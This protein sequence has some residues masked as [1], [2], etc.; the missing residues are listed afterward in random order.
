MINARGFIFSA[1]SFVGLAFAPPTLAQTAST[2]ETPESTTEIR[3]TSPL[4]DAIKA[5]VSSLPHRTKSQIKRS[6]QIRDWYQARDYQPLWLVDGKVDSR[7]EKVI[8]KLLTAY[9]DGL[10]SDDYKATKL[11]ALAGTSD[12]E[13]QADLEVSLSAAVVLYSQHLFTGRVSPSAI[14]RELVIYPSKIS[15]GKILQRLSDT[16]SAIAV[17]DSLAPETPRYDRLRKYLLRLRVLEARGGYTA[18]PKGDVLKPDQTDPRLEALRQRLRQS[19]DLRNGAHVGDVYDGELVEA[20]KN[21]QRR[22][23][24]AIDGV[25]GPGT[26]KQLNVSI[27]NR[28]EQVEL[29]LERRRWMQNDYGTRYVF[30]NLADQVLKLVDDGKTIYAEIV[31][32]GLP[33]HRTPVFSDELKYLEFN[34]YWNVPYSIATKE[35][36][37]RLKRNP[38]TLQSVNIKVLRGG[39][40][41]SPASVPWSSYSRSNFPVRL[42]QEPGPKNALGRVK[43]MFP[44]KYNIYI[45][46]TP[47]KS[48]FSRASRYFSHGCIRL[49]DPFKFARTL[50]KAQGVSSAKI[51]SIRKS[52]KRTV[53][54]LKR[55][56][57]VH[58]AYLTA[59]VNKDGSAHFRRDIYGRDKILAKALNARR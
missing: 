34:P 9:E 7:V 16:D 59:W 43:F 54:Q 52:G 15:A 49:H 19:R 35:Y 58:I 27:K 38:F 42:R 37:P 24:L 14:N 45:H 31:Q 6:N 12:V 55:K 40:V 53:V 56:V 8:Y 3:I 1:I 2:T 5:R 47:A 57:P 25:V 10:I 36:L 50:L 33:F 20:V 51:K 18:V 30:V 23:G 21:Y 28:I 46:D 4:I 41:V 17:L 11:F 44:N 32:V 39:S 13:Q 26:L 22:N 29:N 48:K